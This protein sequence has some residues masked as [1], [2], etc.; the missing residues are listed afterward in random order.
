[1]RSEKKNSEHEGSSWQRGS[2]SNLRGFLVSSGYLL[3]VT[4]GHL[5]LR[6]L[7]GVLWFCGWVGEPTLFKPTVSQH[8]AKSQAHNSANTFCPHHGP[9][10]RER[11]RATHTV[12]VH[13]RATWW[14]TEENTQTEVTA[15]LTECKPTVTLPVGLWTTVLNPRVWH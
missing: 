11:M 9:C 3:C 15:H 10:V 8:P 5:G 2:G 13:S 6:W 1:M 14:A 4:G 12:T 7:S